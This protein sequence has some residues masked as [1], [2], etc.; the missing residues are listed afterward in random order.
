MAI[1]QHTHDTGYACWTLAGS[2][3][4]TVLVRDSI[5][6]PGYGYYV[7]PE[8]PH[9]NVFGATGARC[10]LL[11]MQRPAL[12]LLDD[13]GFDTTRPWVRNG[14][15][16]IWKGLALYGK[17]RHGSASS[18]DIEEL[19]LGAFERRATPARK[20]FRPPAWLSRVREMLDAQ[21]DHPP[22]LTALASEANVHPMHLVRAF[23]MHMGC[24]P[25]EYTQSRRIAHACRIL[26]D[27]ELPLSRLALCLGFYDQSHFT[28]AFTSRIGVSPGA[29]RSL[30]SRAPKAAMRRPAI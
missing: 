21:P 22:R 2:A 3:V 29:Y 23:R 27:S 14:S 12:R 15:E 7:P 28:R 11:E 24:S 9:A 17:L 10:L 13:A 8:T 26:L 18:L 1:G 30:N 19:V 25:G 16:G 6:A 5:A 20:Q 4:D